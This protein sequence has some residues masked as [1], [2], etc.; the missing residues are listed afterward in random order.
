[1]RPRRPRPLRSTT[2]DGLKRVT[3]FND[4][5]QGSC[6]NTPLPASCSSSSDTAWKVTYDADGNRL[7]QTD[8]RKVSTYTSYD[9]LDRPLCRGTA[10]ARSTLP[11]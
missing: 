4:S 6:A 9:A 11:E 1:M 7:T 2:Y 10:S 3:G 8:P 5:D